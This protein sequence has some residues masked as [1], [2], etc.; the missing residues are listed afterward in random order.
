MTL[1]DD[2][3][4][5]ASDGLVCS[6]SHVWPIVD[7]VPVF[8]EQKRSDTDAAQTERHF[9]DQWSR[10]SSPSSSMSVERACRDFLT[11][12]GLREMDFDGKVVLD[13]G[14][15]MGRHALFVAPHARLVVGLDASD[16]I[17]T[18]ARNLSEHRNTL[19][20]MGSALNPPL[21]E[22][23]FDVVYA[24]GVLHHTADPELGIRRCCALVKPGGILA[25]YLYVRTNAAA[26][27]VNLLLRSVTT[28]LPPDVLLGIA[29]C[30]AVVGGSPISSSIS[31]VVNLSMEERYEDRVLDNYD[32][33]GP[34]Y[35]WHL[36]EEEVLG[37]LREEGFEPRWVNPTDK[38]RIVAV[39]RGEQQ[40]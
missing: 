28:R 38:I 2:E 14:C 24:I 32:W 3:S 6:A 12:Y 19:A 22:E 36:K 39:K 26:E 1:G 30:L 40:A 35:Q 7:G 17:E 5:A 25:L 11:Q 10:F 13:V 16:S 29:R 9:A 18:F 4:E 37:W 21:A 34:R 31:Y 23:S 8:L 15:G 20:V 33:Y 27:M